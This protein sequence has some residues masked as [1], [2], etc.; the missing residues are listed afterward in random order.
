[1]TRP[2]PAAASYI[3]R[4]LPGR[5]GWVFELIDLRSG[6]RLQ[7]T[8]VRALWRWLAARPTGLR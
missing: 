2:S 7:L 8:S 4:V 6:E 5:Q 1:M 3:L